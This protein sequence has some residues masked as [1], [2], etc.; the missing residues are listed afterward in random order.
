M[1]VFGS[2]VI[3][4]CF[5]YWLSVFI[6][7]LLKFSL[8]LCGHFP[9][10]NGSKSRMILH[11]QYVCMRNLQEQVKKHSVSKIGLTHSLFE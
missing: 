2:T 5:L 4:V 9:G 11:T 10:R 8:T 1:N 3:G 7:Y 6:V